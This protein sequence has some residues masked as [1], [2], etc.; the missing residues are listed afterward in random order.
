MAALPKDILSFD[1]LEEILGRLPALRILVLGDFFLD[2]YLV[3][4]PSLSEPSLETGLEAR[5]VVEVR[6]GPGAAGTV[7]NNLAALG[8]GQITA[9]SVI[10]DDGE[11]FE[12]L[13][14]LNATRVDTV[15]IISD[16]RRFTPTY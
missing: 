7:T 11:G 10:G 9:V 8:V 4:D 14:G 2:K 12:L 16:P 6:C 13:K 15:G 5:Q 1:R 3:T